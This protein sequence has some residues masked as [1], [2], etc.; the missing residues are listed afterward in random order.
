M[1]MDI[2]VKLLHL[3]S[4]TINPLKVTS[5]LSRH[6]TITIRSM[7][8]CRTVGLS[9]CHHCE[10]RDF[11]LI[12]GKRNFQIFNTVS[13]TICYRY[14]TSAYAKTQAWNRY[15][16]LL[17]LHMPKNPAFGR[18]FCSQCWTSHHRQRVG[19]LTKTK[20]NQIHGR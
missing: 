7:Y 5:T 20:Q 2:I 16:L 6:Q 12:L 15:Y 11:F 9:N 19:W 8:K 10:L 1:L 14:S 13:L 4:R 3:S 18:S 17:L